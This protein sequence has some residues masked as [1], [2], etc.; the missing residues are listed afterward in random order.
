MTDPI[1]RTDEHRIVDRARLASISEG[2][3][4]FELELLDAYIDDAGECLSGIET[5]LAA[6]NWQKVGA[7][8]H[9]LKGASGNIGATCMLELCARLEH[10]ARSQC[11]NGTVKELYRALDAVKAAA[12]QW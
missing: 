4:E 2:D 1:H 10:E 7:V 5:A 6:A 8:A 9:Q 11:N 12:Q 3:R